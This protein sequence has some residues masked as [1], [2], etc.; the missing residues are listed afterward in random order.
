MSEQMAPYLNRYQQIMERIFF[1]RYAA[2]DRAI[3][4]AREEM[5][6]IAAELGIV[7][8]KNLG[9]VV[10]SFR[11]RTALPDSIRATAGQGEAWI[12]R[13]VGRSR[14]RFELTRQIEIV[15]NPLL[16]ETKVPDATPGVVAM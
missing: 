4:F 3:E 13:S 14:Y 11:Y 15:P 16:G 2:G 9:D 1:S 6:R 12:I 8:P 10:Y 5:V 7:L